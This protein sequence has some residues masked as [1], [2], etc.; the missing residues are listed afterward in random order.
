[1]DFQLPGNIVFDDPAGE[2]ADEWILES[3]DDQPGSHRGLYHPGGLGET[4][5]EP[6]SQKD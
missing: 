1:M 2:G 3:I 4:K 5:G 6:F